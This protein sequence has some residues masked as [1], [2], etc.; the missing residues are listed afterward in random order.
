MLRPAV[1][2]LLDAYF[3]GNIGYM[4]MQVQMIQ[5]LVVQ[6]DKMYEMQLKLTGLESNYLIGREER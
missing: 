1:N 6:M 4:E 3:H 5:T 2:T